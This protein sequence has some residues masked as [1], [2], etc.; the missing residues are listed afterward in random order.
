MAVVESRFPAAKRANLKKLDEFLIK[1]K[2]K[3]SK[4]LQGFNYSVKRKQVAKLIMC[5]SHGRF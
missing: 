4:T 1:H 2:F 5:F 3:A